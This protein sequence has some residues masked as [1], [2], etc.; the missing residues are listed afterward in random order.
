MLTKKRCENA[1]RDLQMANDYPKSKYNDGRVIDNAIS[2]FDKL[3]EEHF[4]LMDEFEKHKR[5]EDLLKATEK[6]STKETYISHIIKAISRCDDKEIQEYAMHCL[7]YLKQKLDSFENP[8]A[9]RFE[10]LKEG[11]LVWDNQQKECIKINRLKRVIIS[12]NNYK[13]YI[14]CDIPIE[15]EENRFFP[16]TKA[17]QEKD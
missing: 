6:F 3:I 1:K 15:F 16:L 5:L 11:M 7:F 9:Y 17:Y 8:P 10:E 14:Y 4:E 2:V 12:M 13:C